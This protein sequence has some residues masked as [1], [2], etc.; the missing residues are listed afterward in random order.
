VKYNQNLF[1]YLFTPFFSATAFSALMLLVR[2]QEGHPAS[3]KTDWWGAGMV[4]CLERGADL[5]IAQPCFSKI[6]NGFS[7]LVPAYPGSMADSH[8][9]GNQKTE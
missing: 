9:H 8:K 6:Q 4:I 1:I 2:W 7:F 5:H 3:K